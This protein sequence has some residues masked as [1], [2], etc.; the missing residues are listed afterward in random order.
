M[1]RVWCFPTKNIGQVFPGDDILQRSRMEIGRNGMLQPIA[2]VL[3]THDLS[4]SVHINRKK[5]PATCKLL[6]K[7]CT[8]T[9]SP[10]LFSIC[11]SIMKLETSLANLDAKFSTLEQHR[12]NGTLPKDLLLWSRCLRM[13]SLG[14]MQSY[15]EHQMHFFHKRLLRFLGRSRK[16]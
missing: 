8:T 5:V 13:S 16:L 4:W 1:R 15:W 9:F 10:I 7:F 6:A 3:L 2:S 11:R 12:S 14:L